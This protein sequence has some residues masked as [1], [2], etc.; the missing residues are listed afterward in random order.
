MKHVAFL[1]IIIYSFAVVSFESNAFNISQS[2][3]EF[4]AVDDKKRLRKLLKNNRLKLKKLFSSVTCNADNI[5]VFSAKKNSLAIGE[6][7]IKKLPKK[8]LKT[9]QATIETI[10]PTLFEILVKRME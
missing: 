10:S 5:L 9:Q 2:I 1:I 6:L 4:I 8:V 3:C 7:I